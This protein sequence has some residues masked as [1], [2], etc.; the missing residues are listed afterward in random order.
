MNHKGFNVQL[1]AIVQRA[2]IVY[3]TRSYLG[4]DEA[5]VHSL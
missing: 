1:R 5:H 4:S 2:G 3:D